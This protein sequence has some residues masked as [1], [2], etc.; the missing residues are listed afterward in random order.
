MKISQFY[1][2]AAI[3]AYWD[4][5]QKTSNA[6]PYVGETFFPNDKKTGLDLKYIIGS[7]GVPVALAPSA[8]DALATIRDRIGISVLAG[9][10][11]YFKESYL[12]KE[13]DRQELLRIQDSNDPYLPGILRNIYRDD[14]DLIEGAAVTRERMRMQLLAP[15][16]G[17]VKITVSIDG[18]NMEYNYDPDGSWKANNYTALSGTSVWTASAT[19]DPITDLDTAATAVETA[20]GNKPAYVLMSKKTWNDIKKCDSVKAYIQSTVVQGTK[21]VTDG[22][23]RELIRQ[24]TGLEVI[25]YTKK[26]K[27]SQGATAQAY[28]PD[29]YVT[30]LPDAPLGNTWFG[31]TPFE[32]DLNAG[33]QGDTS[34]VD[35]GVAVKV[36]HTG[37][38]GELAQIQ[39]FAAEVTMPSFEGI[40]DMYVIK[41]A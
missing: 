17:D 32:A 28:Y 29:N 36:L 18:K 4:E 14:A 33:V 30:L 35:T 24:T 41:T 15:L 16:G 11:P 7:S 22:T 23:V 13:K 9:E 12:L 1:N 26:F 10:M 34:I 38:H 6:A 2:S 27:A 37:E 8:F 3:A 25:V 5:Y 19:A 31:T 39:T 40:F 20:T 21:F